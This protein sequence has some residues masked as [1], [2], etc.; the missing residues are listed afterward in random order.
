MQRRR[1]RMKGDS[2]L[3]AD[4]FGKAFFKLPGLLAI[5]EPTALERRPQGLVFSFSVPGFKY[6]YGI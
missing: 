3:D 4:I 5:T 6:L 2:V 1:T